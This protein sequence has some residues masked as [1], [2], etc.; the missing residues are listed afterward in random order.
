MA[1]A[2]RAHARDVWQGCDWCGRTL[3]SAADRRSENYRL[4]PKCGLRLSPRAASAAKFARDLPAS[5]DHVRAFATLLG[6]PDT[7][8][9]AALFAFGGRDRLGRKAGSRS[10][11]SRAS[12]YGQRGAVSA[13]A[14]T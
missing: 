9:H 3:T 11:L 7:A 1:D 10:F 5:V 8:E 2:G 12:Q 14:R 4:L 13:R 6:P